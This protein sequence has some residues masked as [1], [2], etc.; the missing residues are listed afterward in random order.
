MRGRGGICALIHLPVRADAV[1][2]WQQ[3]VRTYS[4]AVLCG[5]YFCGYITS[6]GGGGFFC[7]IARLVCLPSS[8]SSSS[9]RIDGQIFDRV[10][11]LQVF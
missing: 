4:R 1:V 11:R 3:Q 7:V 8:S 5:I 2:E 10:M 6:E 9:Y